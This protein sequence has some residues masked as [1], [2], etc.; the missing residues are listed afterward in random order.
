MKKLYFIGIV[1]EEEISRKIKLLKE[2]ARDKF[3]SGWALRSEGHITVVAPFYYEE[4]KVTEIKKVLDSMEVSEFSIGL[5][6][7][8]SFGKRVIFVKADNHK[9][10]FEYKEE[11]DRK[12]EEFNIKTRTKEFHPHITI[13]FRDLE[14]EVF[15]EAYKYFKDKCNVGVSKEWRM[16]IFENSK[17]GWEILK[18]LDSNNID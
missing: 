11:L 16:V 6:G 14:V 17:D 4:E 3:G 9:R 13:A 2:T 5:K 10:L 8:D 15:D 12:L 18:S 1:F 7:I